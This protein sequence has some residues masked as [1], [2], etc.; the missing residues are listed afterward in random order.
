MEITERDCK[1]FFWMGNQ[2]RKPTRE[3]ITHA[4]SV[5]SEAFPEM[6]PVFGSHGDYGAHRAP[7][8]HTLSFRLRNP[9]GKFCSNVIWLLPDRLNFLTVEEVKRLVNHANGR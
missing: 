1:L 2:N 5:I 8:D 4:R 9:Q 6:T 7:R 3:E